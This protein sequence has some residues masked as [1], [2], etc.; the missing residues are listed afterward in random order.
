MAEGK[1]YTDAVCWAYA[2]GVGTGNGDKFNPTGQ[3]TRQQLA[4]FFYRFVE[5]Q[6]VD[7]TVRSDI[8]KMEG[9]DKVSGY[10]KDAVEWAVGAGLISGSKITNANGETV[11]DLKP[12]DNTTRAQVAVILQRFFENNGL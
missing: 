6:G 1:Y 4:A 3:L 2:T 11:Y 7:I 8:S 10:A 12:K 5:Y 9:A